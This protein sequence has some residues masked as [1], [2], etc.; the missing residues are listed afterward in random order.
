M[1]PGNTQYQTLIRDDVP[2]KNAKSSLYPQGAR[3]FLSAELS[4]KNIGGC[5]GDIRA[6][7]WN[8]I[9]RVE[10]LACAPCY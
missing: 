10:L 2:L 6:G 9:D 8:L 1:E 4:P 7:I 5:N 3:A